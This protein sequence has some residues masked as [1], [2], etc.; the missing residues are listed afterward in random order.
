MKNEFLHISSTINAVG[1]FIANEMGIVHVDDALYPLFIQVFYPEHA[2]KTESFIPLLYQVWLDPSPEH[3]VF[4]PD[5]LQ[6]KFVPLPDFTQVVMHVYPE[7]HHERIAFLDFMNIQEKISPTLITTFAQQIKAQQRQS[8]LFEGISIAGIE[9]A[10]D[11]EG[12]HMVVM[13]FRQML[14]AYNGATPEDTY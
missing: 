7:Q 5:F 3:I 2:T 10:V 1:E 4:L 9:D 12:P 11:H 8:L 6:D 13:T 14:P